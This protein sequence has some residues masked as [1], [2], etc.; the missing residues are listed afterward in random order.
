MNVK[1]IEKEKEKIVLEI[2]GETHT[3]L[4]LLRENVWNAGGEAYY[5]IQ[6]PYLS[7]P[8]FVVKAE[9]PKKILYDAVELI[10]DQAKEFEEKF[11]KCL[12]K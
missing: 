7:V 3:F 9:N 1:V 11:D 4:N 6:H 12:K 2:D 8:K 10:I 5:I